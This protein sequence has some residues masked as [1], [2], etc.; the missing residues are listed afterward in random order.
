MAMTRAQWA[1]VDLGGLRA[2]VNALCRLR[3]WLKEADMDIASL[4]LRALKLYFLEQHSR[5]ES[6]PEQQRTSLAWV[7]FNL[8]IC[9]RAAADEM[10]QICKPNYSVPLRQATVMQLQLW[11]FFESMLTGQAQSKNAFERIFA[12]A[13][14]ILLMGGPRFAHFQRSRL[15][16][17]FPA[18]AVFICSLGKSKS[19]GR[20]RPFYW[21]VP[22]YGLY[23]KGEIVSAF[24]QLVSGA[25]AKADVCGSATAY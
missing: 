17:L 4:E 14:L 18:F 12:S 15:V 25:G 1:L 22:R 19:H 23:F 8:G 9:T 5:G 6:V 24:L 2:K 16:H 20:R 3:E 7:D 10:V 13:W 11:V 21:V